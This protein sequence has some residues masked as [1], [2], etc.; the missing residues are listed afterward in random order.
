MS[1]DPPH[2]DR[3]SDLLDL[4]RRAPEELGARIE[5]LTLAEKVELA[6]RAPPAR[7][8]ELLLHARRPRDVVRALP[9]AELYLTVREIGPADAMP[10]LALAST[11][12]LLHMLDLE[13][14]RADRF[15]AERAG[16]WIALVLEADERAVGRL[17]GALDDEVLA[18]LVH[19]WMRIVPIERDA[20]DVGG[21]GIS[22]SGDERGHVTPDGH[23]R[24]SPSIHEHAPAIRR[25][26]QI[27]FVEHPERYGRVLWQ[28][29][30]ELSAELE[31]QGLQWRQSRLEEHG[32]PSGEEALAL[33][34]PPTGKKKVDA[35]ALPAGGAP[36][37]VLRAGRARGVPAPAVDALAGDVRDRVLFE[38]VAL[39]NRVLV[40]NAGD[41]GDPAAH[42]AAIETAAG[43]VTIAL[44]TRDAPTPARAAS[45]L[46]EVSTIE[47]FREGY[48]RAAELGARARALVRSGWA[49]V[50]ARA[51]DLLD[52]PIRECVEGLLEP[53]PG[54][55]R[56]ASFASLAE[57]EE[58]RASLAM[59]EV[60]GRCLID[61]A[62]FD[63]NRLLRTGVDLP[64]QGYRLSTALLTL[65]AWHATRQTMSSESVPVD[66]AA[67]FVR[68]IASRRTS[69]P[70]AGQRA[71]DRLVQRLAQDQRLEPREI[72]VL[73]AFGRFC[74]ER[75]ADEC[76]DLDPG[77]P[78]DPRGVACLL[79]EWGQTPMQ[80]NARHG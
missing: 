1:A 79:L 13:S 14:W 60:V 8:L 26:L 47:L 4:A 67:D 72:A 57:I 49:K 44:E 51:L 39:A 63:A 68:T 19:R 42:R 7:R 15:D 61:G 48:A 20:A 46:A 35:P 28:S 52:S 56:K 6:L 50:H 36:V 3:L 38:F 43:Y 16:A 78:L 53:R 76:G 77:V 32:Y 2:G 33:Y 75:L 25:I 41:A 62:G 30:W 66:V 12:Q 5:R 34:A 74:L 73:Q 29:L 59:A 71:L 65:L 64:P 54:T 18:L 55:A 45:V 23:Y 80:Y 24:F 58:A 17:L 27:L 21:T 70:E 9:D 37:A 40:A 69:G 31:E 11:E 22:E 10:L